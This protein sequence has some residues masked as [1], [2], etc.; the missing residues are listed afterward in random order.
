MRNEP[1]LLIV[2]WKALFE[3]TGIPQSMRNTIYRW[4]E[5]GLFPRPINWGKKHRNTH[6]IWRRSDLE[7]FAKNST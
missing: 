1:T 3:F 6:P 7:T 2:G 4:M 5:A